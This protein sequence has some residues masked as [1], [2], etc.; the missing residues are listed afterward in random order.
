MSGFRNVA[1]LSRAIN[2]GKYKMTSFRKQPTQATASGIW[3]D[4]SMSPGNPNPNYYASSPLIAQA[5][6]QSNNGGIY[7]GGGE[8]YIHRMMVMT[9]TSTAINSRLM[10]LDYLLYYPFIDESTTDEQILDNSVTLPRF[11]SGEGVQVMAVVVAGQMGGQPFS[12]RYTNSDGV[13]DR[14]SQ[15]VVMNTQVLNGTI[16]TSAPA[17]LNCAGPFIPL[18]QGDKG[19]RSIEAVT[20]GG[21]GDVGL[22]T[23]VLVKPICDSMLNEITAPT[24]IEYFKDFGKLPKIENDAYLNWIIHP[25]GSLS[26]APFHGFVEYVWN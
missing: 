24:E 16:L 13:P 5:M 7:H 23:L 11:T 1:E 22:F 25:T 12:I 18:Q 8:K 3:F 14:I 10:L 15:T 20:I 2:D 21:A 4:L 19:I 26:G 6:S 17:T 9:P